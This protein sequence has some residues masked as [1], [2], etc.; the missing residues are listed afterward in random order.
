MDLREIESLAV[1]V[2]EWASRINLQLQMTSLTDT[3]LFKEGG[4]FDCVEFRKRRQLFY[5][6]RHSHGCEIHTN[7]CKYQCNFQELIDWN[8][9]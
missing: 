7:E 3:K 9:V 6:I 2:D 5:E 1:L 4:R 8:T